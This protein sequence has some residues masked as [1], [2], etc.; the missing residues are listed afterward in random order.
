MEDYPGGEFEKNDI[1]Q[2]FARHFF[3]RN[4]VLTVKTM[5]GHRMEDRDNG[6]KKGET[7][8]FFKR[9]FERLDK[10]MEEKAKERKCCGGSGES[11]CCK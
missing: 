11:S 6:R 7:K 5:E 8:G 3:G 4:R 1:I 9:F 10:K 2:K